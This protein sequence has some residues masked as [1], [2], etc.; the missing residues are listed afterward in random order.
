LF[1]HLAAPCPWVGVGVGVVIW[2]SFSSFTTTSSPVSLP[3]PPPGQE[4]TAAVDKRGFH[5]ALSPPSPRRW[6]MLNTT[7]SFYD[8][9]GNGTIEV[10]S[11]CVC[12]GDAVFKMWTSIL[13]LERR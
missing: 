10:R 5:L 4:E 12:A 13:I 9:V 7:P 8:S 3:P 11:V 6:K 1:P 2:V